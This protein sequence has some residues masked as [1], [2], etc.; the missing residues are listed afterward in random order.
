MH[1][2][3]DAKKLRK[4]AYVDTFATDP[5]KAKFAET[6]AINRGVGVRLFRSLDDARQWISETPR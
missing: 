3:S 1:R 4:I 5:D 2:V 6:V